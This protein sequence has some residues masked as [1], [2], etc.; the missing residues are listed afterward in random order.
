MLDPWNCGYEIGQPTIGK[1]RKR[2]KNIG[3]FENHCPLTYDRTEALSGD[4]PIG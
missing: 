2:K 4:Q 3:K 1:H